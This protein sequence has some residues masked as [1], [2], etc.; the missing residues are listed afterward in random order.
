MIY[1][2]TIEEAR[3]NVLDYLKKSK[4]SRVLDAGGSAW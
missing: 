3:G 1:N 4:F 2:E